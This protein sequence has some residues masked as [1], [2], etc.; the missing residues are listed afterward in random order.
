MKHFLRIFFLL[1][2]SASFISCSNFVSL[3]GDENSSFDKDWNVSELEKLTELSVSGE[4]FEYLGISL[5]ELLYKLRIILGVKCAR[6]VGA[7]EYVLDYETL[8][9]AIASC[10]DDSVIPD[11]ENLNQEEMDKIRIL[12]PDLTDED[13]VENMELIGKFYEDYFM[14]QCVDK[15]VE[16]ISVS[17]CAR[18]VDDFYFNI[19]GNEVTL[20]ELCAALKHPFSGIKVF[21]MKSIA[22][23][24]TAQTM[25]SASTNGDKV[26][27]FRHGIWCFAM[28][29]EGFGTKAQRLQFVKD[30]SDAHEKGMKYVEKLAEMDLHNNTASMNYFNETT[31]CTYFTLITW[32][33]ETGCTPVSYETACTAIKEKVESGTAIE[34]YST[35]SLSQIIS[36]ISE[37][38]S[39]TFMYFN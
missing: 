38:D 9:N 25:G 27:A 19:D 11:F 2:I 20:Y 13:I 8:E 29:K 14:S 23:N 17:S 18:S 6:S 26:D 7:Y 3:G 4:D 16:N 24:L 28:A 39:S 33:I 1:F 36:E 21:K 22:E 30:F 34:N 35:K 31:T 5:D 15:V 12:L 37:I 10:K 32:N